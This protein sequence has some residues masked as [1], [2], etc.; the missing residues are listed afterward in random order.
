MTISSTA[1]RIQYT[2]GGSTTEFAF[3]YLFYDESHLVVYLTDLSD[4]S[5]KQTLGTDYTVTG[6][7][8]DAGGEVTFTTAPTS[9]YVVTIYRSVPLT[10]TMDLVDGEGFEADTLEQ[11]FDMNVMAIQQLQDSLDRAVILSVTSTESAPDPEEYITELNT[12]VANAQTYANNASASATAAASSATAAS[13]AQTASEAAQTAAETAQTGAETAQT[14]AETAKT[15]AQAAQT[16]AETAQTAAE[17]AETAAASS[18]TAAAASA[19]EADGYKDTAYTYAQSAFTYKASAESARDNALTYQNAALAS[20]TAAATSETNA[21]TSETNAAASATLAASYGIRGGDCYL[22]NS[23]SVLTLA[24]ENGKF[25]IIN[26]AMETI[27]SAGVT[28][29]VSGKTTYTIYYVYAYMNSGTM[30]LEV[31]TTVP[32]INS[33][34]GVMQKTGDATRT[35]VGKIRTNSSGAVTD[36]TSNVNCISYF[37]RK[38]RRAYVSLGSVSTTATSATQLS[39]TYVDMIA[40]TDETILCTLLSSRAYNSVA[41]MLCSL[42]LYSN[43]SSISGFA[44]SCIDDAAYYGNGMCFRM[45]LS[46][47]EHTTLT[48]WGLTASSGTCVA[49]GTYILGETRG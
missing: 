24:R 5:T 46:S 7:G 22:S 2:A 25:L 43:G 9:G 38:T 45:P 1:N 11:A 18:A 31:S 40:W 28:L 44:Y 32:V 47:T 41:S 6:A 15:N 20:Q 16:A 34:T 8:E 19:T 37:N 49:E 36:G 27:P 26:G 10:Q 48:V 29:T 42:Y 21:S 23:S 30:T 14:G 13:T 33:T 35:L 39:S 17:T 12:I 4:V 3:P